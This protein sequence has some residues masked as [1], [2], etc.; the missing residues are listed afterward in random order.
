MG[1]QRVLV[2]GDSEVARLVYTK[3][4]G[5]FTG[6]KG[7]GRSARNGGPVRGRLLA[8]QGGVCGQ[9]CRVPERVPHCNRCAGSIHTRLLSSVRSRRDSSAGGGPPVNSHP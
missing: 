7:V 4:Q 5:A 2:A 8:Q 3:E 6:Q 9:P 1:R